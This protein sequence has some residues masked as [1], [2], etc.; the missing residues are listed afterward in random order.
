MALMQVKCKYRAYK[1]TPKILE[2][3]SQ[4]MTFK[5]VYRQ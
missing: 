2:Q 3:V 4:K 1:E 5:K